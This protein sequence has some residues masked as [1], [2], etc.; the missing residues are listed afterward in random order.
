MADTESG[1]ERGVSTVPPPSVT[2]STYT[3]RGARLLRSVTSRYT[4]LPLEKVSSDVLV[5]VPA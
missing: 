5:D 1:E 2:P 4:P 3:S